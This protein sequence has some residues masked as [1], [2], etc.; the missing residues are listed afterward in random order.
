MHTKQVLVRM[1]DLL[2]STLCP[3]SNELPSLRGDGDGIADMVLCGALEVCT[4]VF[5][6]F[7][8][9]VRVLYA[10]IQLAEVACINFKGGGGIIVVGDNCRTADKIKNIA[11]L[12]F[13]KNGG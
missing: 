5:F 10:F 13:S 6:F 8:L 2:I 9:S 7:L 1:F 4:T 11:S 12:F 3:A